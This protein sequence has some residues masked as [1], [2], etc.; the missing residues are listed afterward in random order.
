MSGGREIVKHLRISVMIAFTIAWNGLLLLGMWL[1]GRGM[2]YQSSQARV[3]LFIAL[4]GTAIF[5]LAIAHSSRVQAVTLRARDNLGG[6]RQE[7]WFIAVLAL[8]MSLMLVL[9]AA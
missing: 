8:F 3:F 4:L 2:S 1:G 5:A 7:L 9:Q 6:L